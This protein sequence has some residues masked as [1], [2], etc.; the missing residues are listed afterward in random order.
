VP[1]VGFEDG[2]AA[3][4]VDVSAGGDADAADLGGQSVAEII[5]VEVV[6]FAITSKSSG[7]VRT[8]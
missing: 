2:V 6:A 3:E 4:V 7:R 1:W 8:C 5:A